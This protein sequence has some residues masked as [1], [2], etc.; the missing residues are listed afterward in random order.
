MSCVTPYENHKWREYGT[1]DE[2][3]PTCL[4]CGEPSGPEARRQL[5]EAEQLA[6][7]RLT[8][9]S[10]SGY[11]RHATCGEC[12]HPLAVAETRLTVSQ[13]LERE[14]VLEGH[15]PACRTYNVA[16]IPW[17]YAQALLA[18]GDQARPDIKMLE[19][20]TA[21]Q[22]LQL[23]VPSEGSGQPGGSPGQ[24]APSAVGG[25]GQ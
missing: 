20:L 11:I 15:C 6:G 12:E 10:E 17:P 3:S 8:Y 5:H 2:P 13:P 1:E 14:P 7:H 25:T 22:S 9:V 19:E 21:D 24:T 4:R 16:Q 23:G 18:R